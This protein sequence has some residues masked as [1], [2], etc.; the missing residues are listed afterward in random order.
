M[1]T[2]NFCCVIDKYIQICAVHSFISEQCW[3][4]KILQKIADDLLLFDKNSC[5]YTT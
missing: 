2:D 1:R 4:Q 3:L 5:I